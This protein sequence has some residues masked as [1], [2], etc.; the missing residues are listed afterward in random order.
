MSINKIFFLAFAMMLTA[1]CTKDTFVSHTGN[2]PSEERIREL[3]IGQTKRDVLAILGSPS[4]VPPLDDNTWIYMSSDI[5]QVAFMK[6]REIDRRLLVIRFDHNGEIASIKRY[7]KEHGDDVDISGEST[8][9]VGPEQ[10]FFRRYFGGA[11]YTPLP[12][13]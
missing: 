6:P 9:V 1:S 5:K 7:D 2:M 4:S 10:G 13:N 3:E 11:S 12:P 8:E